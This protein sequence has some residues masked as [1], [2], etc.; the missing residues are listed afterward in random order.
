MGWTARRVVALPDRD[1]TGN[2]ATIP[3]NP[4]R[5]ALWVS[6]PSGLGTGTIRVGATANGHGVELGASP[7]KLEGV[8][9]SVE[10]Y[11]TVNGDTI[12]A[13]EIVEA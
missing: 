2:R 13:T 12:R 11:G 6:A 4:K 10:F 3:R 8:T 9:E 1:I 7:I 5:V